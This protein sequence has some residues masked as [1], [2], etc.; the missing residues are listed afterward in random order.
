MLRLENGGTSHMRPD[1]A[2][3][4]DLPAPASTR[5]VDFDRV[6]M[7]ELTIASADGDAFTATLRTAHCDRVAGRE[8]EETSELATGVQGTITDSGLTRG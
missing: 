2:P 7:R 8:V 1:Y 6:E 3:S 4:T 5:L